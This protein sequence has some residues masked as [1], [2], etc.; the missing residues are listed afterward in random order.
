MPGKERRRLSAALAISAI[1][2]TVVAAGAWL[3]AMAFYYDD[4]S[5]QACR[6][7]WAARLAWWRWCW[8][9]WSRSPRRWRLCSSGETGPH[10]RVQAK[11]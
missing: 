10:R 3:F 8:R 2:L 4:S 11:R 1:G 6:P 7:I 9:R 5:D